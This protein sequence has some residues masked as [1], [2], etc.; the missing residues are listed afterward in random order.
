[1]AAPAVSRVLLL[2]LPEGANLTPT[3]DHR[4]F[5]FA[6]DQRA[7][8]PARCAASRRRC[9]PAGARWPSSINGRVDRGRRRA[10][11]SAR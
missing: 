11:G 3:V 7:S 4:I 1:M 10:F 8:S 9:R 2:F 5:L 6:S